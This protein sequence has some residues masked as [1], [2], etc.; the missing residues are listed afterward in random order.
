M[1]P[2][3]KA[4][5]A[6]PTVLTVFAVAIVA[7]MSFAAIATMAAGSPPAGT[8]TATVSTSVSTS[9]QIQVLSVT[10]PMSPY[11]PGG[12]VVSVTLKNTGDAAVTSLN[13]TLAT[14][15]G[16]NSGAVHSPYWFL[17]DASSANPLLAGQSIQLNE[18]LL[19]AGFQRGASYPLTIYG[20]T[21]DG[22]AFSY[23]VQVQVQAPPSSSTA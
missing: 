3:R 20:M 4:I 18:T 7:A 14:T 23:T 5:G 9:G 8:M 2:K 17:F 6:N 1:N 10:G 12:P 22:A 21:A 11:N 19:G 15:A 13:A 16:T